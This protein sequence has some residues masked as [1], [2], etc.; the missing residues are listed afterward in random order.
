[1]SASCLLLPCSTIKAGRLQSIPWSNV[2]KASPRHVL[3]SLSWEAAVAPV[4]DQGMSTVLTARA[5]QF[6]RRGAGK[7]SGA[8]AELVGRGGPHSWAPS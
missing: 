5:A 4:S 1:M 2:T 6:G 8:D 7:P 3:S